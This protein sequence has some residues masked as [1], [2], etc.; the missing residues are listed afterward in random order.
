[1]NA[2]K[3]V[4]ILVAD[5]AE[6]LGKKPA[7]IGLSGGVDSAVIALLCKRAIG[8]ENVYCYALPYGDQSS[9]DAKLL[10]SQHGLQLETLDIAPLVDSYPKEFLSDDLAK[11]NI[12]SRVRMV[13]LYG[14]SN[15]KNGIV[16]GTGNRT[17]LL[18]GYMTK[19]GDGGVDVE[20]IGQLYKTDVWAIARVL[21]VPTCIIDKP[22][23]AELWAEQ[24]DEE[25]LSVRLGTKVTYRMLDKILID[26]DSV[27]PVDMWDKHGEDIV[28]KVIDLIASSSHKINVPKSFDVSSA[29]RA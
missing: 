24:T 19:Y 1:M 5:L 3:M 4:D 27:K 10:A 29:R 22:P 21:G 25:E 15:T 16:I 2:K 17:E 9:E 6:F 7:I 26:Y 18:F 14:Y 8:A 11:G 12:K 20:P 23:S 13:T 28:D